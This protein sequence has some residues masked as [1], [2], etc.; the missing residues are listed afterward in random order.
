MAEKNIILEEI[1]RATRQVEE[2]AKM[3]IE[4]QSKFKEEIA[5]QFLKL[6]RVV[7]S[8][9][10]EEGI[11]LTNFK[12]VRISKIVDTLRKYSDVIDTEAELFAKKYGF[13]TEVVKKIFS[14]KNSNYTWA[15]RLES[16]DKSEISYYILVPKD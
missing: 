13:S 9:M 14:T 6:Q 15:R 11:I 8:I 7:H 4:E 16:Y 2:V 12:W 3:R 10:T 1:A 5:K